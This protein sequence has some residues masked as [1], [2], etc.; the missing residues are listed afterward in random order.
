MNPT[1]KILKLAMVTGELNRRIAHRGQAKVAAENTIASLAPVVAKTLVEYK[2]VDA[3]EQEKVAQHLTDHSQAL[4]YLDAVAKQVPAAAA[5]SSIGSP[6]QDKVA[7]ANFQPVGARPGSFDET[8][9][10]R[11]FREGILGRR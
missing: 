8:D 3:S 10:G 5:P 1:Q 4:K 2:R 7:S 6:V 11:K 9:A